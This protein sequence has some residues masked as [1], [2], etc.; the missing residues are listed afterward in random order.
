MHIRKQDSLIRPYVISEKLPAYVHVEVWENILYKL[1]NV[2]DHNAL[3]NLQKLREWI[4]ESIVV[5]ESILQ[6][7]IKQFNDVLDN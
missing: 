3:P 4:R 1:I 2:R 5:K 6:D 7:K